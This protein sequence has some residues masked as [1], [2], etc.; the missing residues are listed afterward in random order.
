MDLK[1]VSQG[2]VNVK[3]DLEIPHTP[4]GIIVD[5]EKGAEGSEYPFGV[6]HSDLYLIRSLP[7]LDGSEVK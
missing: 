1:L 6:G 2:I 4:N 7:S 3:Y 5:G